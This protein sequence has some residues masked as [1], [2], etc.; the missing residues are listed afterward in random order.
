MGRFNASPGRQVPA[1]FP[2]G[3]CCTWAWPWVLKPE[4]LV[5]SETGPVGGGRGL[6]PPEE[7]GAACAVAPGLV[8]SRLWALWMQSRV[9]KPFASSGDGDAVRALGLLLGVH[10]SS[11]FYRE[12]L[13]WSLGGN[14]DFSCCRKHRMSFSPAHVLLRPRRHRDLGGREGRIPA[15]AG[16]VTGPAARTVC[17]SPAMHCRL[18]P[19]GQQ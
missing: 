16:Q 6:L 15:S 12:T 2:K 8:E 17:M 5:K 3:G 7:L 11:T 19:L 9:A 18:P 13:S 10:R 4:S 14:S 1:A